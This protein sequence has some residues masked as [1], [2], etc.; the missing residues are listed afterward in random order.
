M[1]TN[2]ESFETPAF[3]EGAGVY[4]FHGTIVAFNSLPGSCSTCDMQLVR[5]LLHRVNAELE[6]LF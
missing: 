6:Y 5:P 1:R 2:N 4:T 3:L